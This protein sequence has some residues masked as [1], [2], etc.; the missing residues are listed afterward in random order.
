[1]ALAMR[2]STHPSAPGPAMTTWAG[3]LST[4][5]EGIK[6]SFSCLWFPV[7]LCMASRVHSLLSACPHS[8]SI[9]SIVPSVTVSP[10]TQ[11]CPMAWACSST[12]GGFFLVNHRRKEL[13]A[14]SVCRWSPPLDRP[15]CEFIHCPCSVCDQ[16]REGP[17]SWKKA[18][19]LKQP[20]C[21]CPQCGSAF[22]SQGHWDPAKIAE[23]STCRQWR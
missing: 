20:G 1:M 2:Y 7:F 3:G 21:K 23:H 12:P 14:G 10:G 18:H 6:T 5:S 8:S 16:F 17:T 19:C 9:D 4:Q 13:R 15:T 22:N 11:T